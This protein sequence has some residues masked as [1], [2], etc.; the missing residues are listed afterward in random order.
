MHISPPA[1]AVLGHRQRSPPYEGDARRIRSRAHR[2]SIDPSK[3]GD[4][5]RSSARRASAFCWD[6]TEYIG[7]PLACP[8]PSVAARLI[9]NTGPA[10]GRPDVWQGAAHSQT[11]A[12]SCVASG[13]GI[14]G[15]GHCR[16]SPFSRGGSQRTDFGLARRSS[17]RFPPPAGVAVT[18]LAALAAHSARLRRGGWDDR[19]VHRRGWRLFIRKETPWPRSCMHGRGCRRVSTATQT[20]PGRPDLPEG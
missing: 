1:F 9:G 4:S 20:R 8:G 12:P 10:M 3:P 15:G 17:S 5:D 16:V 11:R 13:C 7:G 18:C 19:T 6:G 14:H 2:G